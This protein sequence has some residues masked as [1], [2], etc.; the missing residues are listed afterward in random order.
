MILGRLHASLLGYMLVRKAAIQA[1]EEL[2]EL[3][4]DMIFNAASYFN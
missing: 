3:V 1:G 2:L 4:K